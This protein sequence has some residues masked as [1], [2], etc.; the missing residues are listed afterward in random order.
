MVKKENSA[1]T[2]SEMKDVCRCPLCH[3]PMKVIALK[4]LICTNN[5]TFDF[6]SKY[7]KGDRE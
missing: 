4:S 5:H 7:P 1:E 2:V 6:A 3:R